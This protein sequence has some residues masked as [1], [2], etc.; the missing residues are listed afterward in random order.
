M[1]L[2]LASGSPRRLELL[3]QIGIEPDLI[4]P[5]EIDETPLNNET[6]RLLAGR[7]AVAKAQ[8]IAV[9]HAGAIILGADTVVACGRRCLPKAATAEEARACLKL[10]SGR[11]HRVHTGIAILS[12]EQN[13]SRI[14]SSLVTFKKLTSAE[15]DGYIRSG[16]WQGKAGGYAVQGKAARYIRA[17]SG[18]YSGV[19]GLPL[20]ETAQLLNG[21]GY[22]GASCS[23]NQ[24]EEQVQN[25][26]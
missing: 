18:S 23:D 3:R 13:L 22:A 4:D 20:F 14:V 24:N 6:P 10:L 11:R 12:G 25:A 2:V 17:L 9:R 19:V 16:E 26:E 8:A 15:I 7:L 21:I 5:A 1:R